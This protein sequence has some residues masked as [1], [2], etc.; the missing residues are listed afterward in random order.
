MPYILFIALSFH[1]MFEG[2]AIGL[3][4]FLLLKRL[5]IE[6][7]NLAVGISLHK[8]A[9]ALSLGLQFYKNRVYF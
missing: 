4:V 5:S 8:W 9:E 6:F 2:I 7:F 3:S 1:G